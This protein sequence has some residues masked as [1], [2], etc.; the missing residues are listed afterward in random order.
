MLAFIL[1][2]LIIAVALII[3]SI[4]LWRRA[5]SR[6]RFQA[7]LTILFFLFVL[8]PTVPLTLFVSMLLTKSTEMLM[9]PGVEQA[10]SQSIDVIRLQLNE[11]CE[12]FVADHP[13]IFRLP[14]QELKKRGI[15]YI[16][17]V[18]LQKE[19]PTVSLLRT[20][21]PDIFSE[22]EVSSTISDLPLDQSGQ[23]RGIFVQKDNLSLYQF[24]HPRDDSTA[25]IIGYELPGEIKQAREEISYALRNY[26]SLGLLRETFIEQKL[27][28]TI[29]II[30]IFFLVLLAVYVARVLSRGISEPI[31][32]LT[33]GMRRIGAG[34]LDYTVNVRAKDEIAFLVESFNRMAK[35]LKISRENLQRAERAAAWRDVARQIAHEIKNPLTPMQFSLFRIRSTLPEGLLE[36]KDLQESFNILEEEI[37]SMRRVADEFSQFARMPHME[38]KPE[39]INEII[40]SSTR[41]FAEEKSVHLQLDLEEKLPPLLLDREQFRRV[42]HNLVK[43]A[44]EASAP[45]ESILI[46]TR[47]IGNSVRIEIIDH[48]MGMDEETIEKATQPYFTTKPEG[49]GLGLFIVSRIVKDHNGRLEIQSEKNKGTT[50]SIEIPV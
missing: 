40:R 6:S 10:L 15:H 14:D 21:S 38:L 33:A 2:T 16:A 18:S 12:Q 44:R 5:Q 41:L 23:S 30:F 28:W 27:I 43:N 32:E 47:K 9:F 35:E 45:E 3:Y 36:N 37:A 39:N 4:I 22:Q 46:R 7:R 31:Q 48:G 26:A 8:I 50:I 29:A 24:Y 17:S 13:D 20:L 1:W 42:I 19:K 34:E 11:R 25:L 49:S